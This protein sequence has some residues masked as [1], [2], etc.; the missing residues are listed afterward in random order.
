[1][2]DAL[3]ALARL[4]GAW[5]Q[6]PQ[7]EPHLTLCATCREALLADLERLFPPSPAPTAKTLD[8]SLVMGF[9]FSDGPRETCALHP[10]L[11]QDDP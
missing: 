6:D 10:W 4:R 9:T 2:P 1:M 5:S 3:V 8:G 7:R 11:H